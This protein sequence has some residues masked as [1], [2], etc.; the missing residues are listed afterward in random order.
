MLLPASFRITLLP[1]PH[2]PQCAELR[3]AGLSLQAVVS[4]SEQQCGQM[5][6][7]LLAAQSRE[8]DMSQVGLMGARRVGG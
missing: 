4:E 6:M 3:G 7:A 2:P 5:H 1:T 8:E